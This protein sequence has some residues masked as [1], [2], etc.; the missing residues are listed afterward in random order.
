MS[1]AVKAR[2]ALLGVCAAFAVLPALLGTLVLPLGWDEIVYAG[3]YASFAHG[4]EI[5]FEA[6]RTRGVP[7]LIAPVATWSDSVLLLRAWLGLLA[8]GALFAGFLPWL[9]VFRARPYVV[10]VAAAA[11]GSLWITLFYATSA[12]PNHYTAM[13]ATAAVGCFLSLAD[14][15]EAYRRRVRLVCGLVLGLG[16]ATLMRPNDAIWIAAPLLLAP[17]VYLPWRP[18]W[19]TLMTTVAMGIAAGMAPWVAEAVTRFG[20]IGSRLALAEEQQGGMG[21]AFNLPAVINSLDGPLLCRPCTSG[22]WGLP[23]GWWWYVL[24]LLVGAGI[25]LAVRGQNAASLRVPGETGPRGPRLSTLER[26][27][28]PLGRPDLPVAA[29]VLPTIVAGSTA[30]T[31]LFLLHYTAPRFLLPTY[32]LLALPAAVALRA[33]WEAA[34]RRS[35]ALAAVLLFVLVGH[36]GIQLAMVYGHAN[37][38]SAARG[39]WRRV[40]AVLREA[41]VGRGCVLDGNSRVIPVAYTAGCLPAKLLP[42]HPPDALVLRNHMPRHGR[43]T[44][45]WSE[46]HWR[47]IPVPDTYNKQWWVAVPEEKPI[48]PALP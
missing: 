6:P 30:L 10:P 14:G 28:A 21:A 27:V 1:V 4:L 23:A 26:S 22:G 33:L 45:I 36:L 25:W 48:A 3:R 29:L 9:G 38:Q 34:R 13:G 12:M 46:R 18:A 8:G 40:T 35:R 43:W 2:L 31:Y 16:V 19:P 11:Y 20:G 39:D 32:A 5:P 24:P 17:L 42:G 7:T 15:E 37:I 44:G 47:V 41:G